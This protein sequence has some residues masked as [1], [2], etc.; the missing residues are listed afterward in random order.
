LTEYLLDTNVVIEWLKGQPRSINL[1]RTLNDSGALLGINAVTIAELYSGL[2]ET[3][4]ARAEQ[5]IFDALDYWVIEFY[6]ARLAGELRYSYSRR[7]VTL[8][9]TDALIAAHAISRDA[10]LV[11]DNLRDFPM[12]ELK[13]ITVS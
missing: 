5:T 11:T 10:T 8:P 13:L 7:G 12:P 6:V 9:A 4:I 3:E 1:V 2:K